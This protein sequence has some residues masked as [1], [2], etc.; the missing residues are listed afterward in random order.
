MLSLEELFFEHEYAPHKAATVEAKNEQEVVILGHLRSKKL[1]EAFQLLALVTESDRLYELAHEALEISESL[2]DAEMIKQ[3]AELQFSKRNK[4]DFYVLAVSALLR[5]N[6][7]SAVS[8]VLFT[9]LPEDE[10]DCGWKLL[11]RHYRKQNDLKKLEVIYDHLTQD[12]NKISLAEYFL[13]SHEM[14]KNWQSWIM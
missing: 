1:L 6:P 8:F 2:R 11:E 4:R 3:L 9:K 12:S 14:V 10:A 7:D 5:L 13:E